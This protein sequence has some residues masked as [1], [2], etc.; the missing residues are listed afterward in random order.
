[1]K[2]I[3]LMCLVL[4]SISSVC[5]ADTA[6]NFSWKANVDT[7]KGYKITMDNSSN[8]VGT[9]PDKNTT[10]FKYVLKDDT[11]CHSFSIFAYTDKDRSV[12]GDYLVW[13]PPKPVT[14][15][16]FILTITPVN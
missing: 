9:I 10:T 3:I 7:T 6:I 14:P 11:K 15:S 1:M 8:V 2:K 13:C 5:F 4:L 16:K 12:C